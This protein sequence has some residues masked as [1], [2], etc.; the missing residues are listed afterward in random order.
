MLVCVLTKLLDVKWLWFL[1]NLKL[2]GCLADDMGLGKTIQILSLLLL[3]KHGK[4]KSLPHLLVVPA[5]LLANWQAEILR[6]SPTISFLII[7]SSTTNGKNLNDFSEDIIKD[8]D[9]I[10]TTYGFAQR[11]SWLTKMDWDLVILDEA[12]NIKNPN[13]KQ[14]RAVKTLKSNVRFIL[15]GTPIENRLMDLWSLFD[16][17][18][19]GLLGTSK[20]FLEYSKNLKGKSENPDPQISQDSLNSKKL[21]EKNENSGP[22]INQDGLNSKELGEKS[23]NS[24]SQFNQ[25]NQISQ[26]N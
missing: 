26:S 21:E 22:Q 23:E 13:T 6:F 1:Y 4:Q 17:I 15:S 9:L 8:Y 2:G 14:T 12:Q 19:P 11:L 25:N 24:G 3:I 16:F 5:S 18:S 10:I 20:A 7:H